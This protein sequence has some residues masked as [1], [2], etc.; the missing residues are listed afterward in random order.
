M[1]NMNSKEEMMLEESSSSD[2]EGKVEE[3]KAKK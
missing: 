2:E 3:V 1:R